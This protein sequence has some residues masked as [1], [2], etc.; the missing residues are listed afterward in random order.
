[1]YRFCSRRDKN[2]LHNAYQALFKQDLDK[3]WDKEIETCTLLAN[4]MFP[5]MTP[6]K[7]LVTEFRKLVDVY[8][9][10]INYINTLS[11]ADQI[12]VSAAAASVFNYTSHARKI[13]KFLLDP[14]NQ[15]DEIHNCV[16][17]DTQKVSTFSFKG[18][19]VRRFDLE[20]VLDKGSCPLLGLSLYNFVP[21]CKTCNDPPLKGTKTIGVSIEEIKHLSPTNPSYDFENKV[22]FVLNPKFPNVSDTI[23]LNHPSHYYIDFEYIDK[24]YAKSVDL[25]AL[26][27][28]YNNDFL[29]EALKYL[30]MLN[31][32]TPQYINAIAALSHQSYDE[33]YEEQFR[34]KFD[35][36]NHSPYKKA[37]ED[38]LGISKRILSSKQK[39]LNT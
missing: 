29:Q 5:G 8:M 22:F 33:V 7:L 19:K 32:Y 13:A 12:S 27:E 23:R 1:M 6:K 14:T 11:P 35:R 30:D 24:T 2:S 28:R 36:T 34:V 16:Y 10:Y 31:K 37:K 20:H 4:A 25:F 39:A 9:Y 15:F 38:I 17:C 3:K 18:K 21:S 26:K